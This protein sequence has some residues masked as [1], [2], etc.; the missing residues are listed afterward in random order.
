MTT[1]LVVAEGQGW[2]LRRHDTTRALQFLAMIETMEPLRVI[3][4]GTP[5]IRGGT[6]LLRRFPDRRLTL[7]DA[8]GLFVMKS[9]RAGSC[10]STD[11]HMG[12]TGVPLAIGRESLGEPR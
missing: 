11:R 3:G 8:V 2:F 6:E 5:E 9:L 1:S 7:T 12:L 10:W 4:V